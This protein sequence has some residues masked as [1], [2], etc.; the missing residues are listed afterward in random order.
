MP[1]SR[2]GFSRSSRRQVAWGIG[3]GA[4]V[5]VAAPSASQANIMGAGVVLVNEEKATIVR[6]WGSLSAFLTTASAAG[7]G[8]HCAMGIG[9]VTDQAFAAGVASLPTPLDESD[10]D[11]W[12][13]HRFFDV[14]TPFATLTES[15]VVN[16]VTAIEFEVDTKAMRKWVE[17]MTV[18]AVLDS[19]EQGTA[20]MNVFFDSRMLLKLS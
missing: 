20:S 2:S 10:W 17:N 8:F 5:V 19:V 13:Y 11:G 9:L 3:P 14:H 1:R 4:S 12:M 16:G 15:G 7:D 18:V 6:I